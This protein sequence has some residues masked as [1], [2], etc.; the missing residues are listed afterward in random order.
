MWEEAFPQV[1]PAIRPATKLLESALC[2]VLPGVAEEMEVETRFGV[3]G[4]DGSFQPGVSRQFAASVL[5][6]LETSA[7]HWT[8]TGPWRQ[9][10]DR[11]YTVGGREVRSSA[12][13]GP[14]GDLAVSH[15]SKERVG[16]VDFGFG[17][18]EEVMVRLS[19]KRER[20]LDVSQ[21]PGRVDNVTCV[22]LKQRKRFVHTPAR[23]PAPVFALDVTLVFQADTQE[24]AWELLR[25]GA[26]SSVEVELECL[27]AA[28]YLREVLGG[29]VARLATSCLL[30]TVD[31]LLPSDARLTPHN[32]K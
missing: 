7:P 24:A 3:R 32:C 27:A 14:G 29:D 18:E 22:R 2:D 11:F 17:A 1:G 25:L 10:V 5:H 13:V 8:S 9:S 19:V 28:V 6:R 12:G 26:T 30:K 4:A 31:W 23:A 21:L 15:M 16:H 20:P